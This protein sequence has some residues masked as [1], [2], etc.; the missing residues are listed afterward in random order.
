MHGGPL[1]ER[2]LRAEMGAAPEAVETEPAARW[3]G[4]PAQRAVADDPGAEQRR[5]GHVL[6]ALGESVGEGGRY[7]RV[8]RVAAVRVPAGVLGARA[9]VL[10]PAQ[11][12]RARPVGTAQPRDAHPVTDREAAHPGPEPGH[13]ADDLVP[14]RHPGAAHRQIALGD[15]EVGAAHPARAHVHEQFVIPRAGQRLL[16][17]PE[18]TRLDGPRFGHGP[19]AHRRR[20]SHTSSVERTAAF[21][22]RPAPRMTSVRI[23]TT[24][25][26]GEGRDHGRT[27]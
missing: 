18:D 22:A 7:G 19:R 16:H 4:G 12:V 11:A 6:Q 3:Q 13:R 17:Q 2:H 1:G 20:I 24:R 5:Q 15:M 23:R 25:P 14:R 10:G 8:L 27:T 9:Q 26:I 21:G